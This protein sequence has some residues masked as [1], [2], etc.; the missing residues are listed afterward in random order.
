MV[1]RI[2]RIP[3]VTIVITV[4]SSIGFD[5]VR[6]GLTLAYRGSGSVRIPNSFYC[7]ISAVEEMTQRDTI[8]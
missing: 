7:R 8:T 1:C 3:L 5:I 4:G 6:H 2:I